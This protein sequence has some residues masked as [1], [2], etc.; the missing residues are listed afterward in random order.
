MAPAPDMWS[1]ESVA[2]EPQNLLKRY[3]QACSATTWQPV[4]DCFW[5]KSVIPKQT[6]NVTLFSDGRDYSLG[7][8][9]MNIRKK[10]WTK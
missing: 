5:L 9:D 7:L 3:R 4:I 2:T 10:G 6:G 8:H 1:R